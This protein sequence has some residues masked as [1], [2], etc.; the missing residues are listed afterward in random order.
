MITADQL[1]Q[2]FPTNKNLDSLAVILNDL[3]PKYGITTT[4][5]IAGFLAQCGHE[6]LGFTR[7]RENLNYSSQG[8]LKVF[9]KYFNKAQADLY[10]R[11]PEKIANR[12][13]A[14]R[15]G[16]GSELTSDGWKFRGA[17]PLQLT[18][19]NNFTAFGNSIGKTTDEV[20]AYVA[21]LQGGVESACWFWKANNINAQ[22]DQ[23]DIDGM[24]DLIN[25]GRETAVYGDTIGFEDRARLYKLAKQI[26]G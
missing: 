17:G 24:S 19:K 25:K 23:D 13:Y 18:G 21:T 6:S 2:L 22:C 3:L 9:P 16:N 10:Q 14:N 26:I 4:N 1:K 12:V 15:M 8:L 5:R 7:L 11:Q 20:A